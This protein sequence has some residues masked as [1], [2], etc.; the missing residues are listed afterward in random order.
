MSRYEAYFLIAAL[1]LFLAFLA[2]LTWFSF[3]LALCAAPFV[4]LGVRAQVRAGVRIGWI[5]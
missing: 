2:G 1:F 3:V 5:T 4:G